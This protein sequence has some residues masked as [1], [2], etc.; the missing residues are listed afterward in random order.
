[1]EVFERYLKQHKDAKDCPE[2]ALLLAAKYTRRL[3]N[4]KRAKELLK[5]YAN[6]FS[7]EHQ[8]LAR[9]IELELTT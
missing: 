3:D 1:V 9:T 8:Q 2:V 4:S 6:E 7:E 5:K